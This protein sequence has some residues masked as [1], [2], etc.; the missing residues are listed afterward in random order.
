VA[1]TPPELVLLAQPRPGCDEQAEIE[2]LRE[3][4]PLTR[5]VVL[6][7]SWCEGE[8]RTGRPLLGVIRLYWYEFPAWW[9]ACLACLA[10]RESPP[11]TEPLDDVRAGQASRQVPAMAR[12][13]GK[14]DINGALVAID[15][16]DFAV[17]QSLAASLVAE[18]W[19]CAWHPRHRPSLID[20]ADSL[21]AGLWDGSQLHAA[22]AESL[23]AFCARLKQ[24]EAPVVALLDFPRVDHIEMAST[25]GA[26]AVLGKPYSVAHLNAELKRLTA[27]A[28]TAS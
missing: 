23:G 3:V 5:V 15:A 17:F 4:A 20:T 16:T 21:A 26:A 18:G 19:Q 11:W 13:A 14:P 22:E 27:A 1:E 2:V 6:A 24:Y 12:A 9:R 8:L 28:T 10:R 7:G 25:N